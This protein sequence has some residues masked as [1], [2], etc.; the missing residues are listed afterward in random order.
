MEFVLGLLGSMLFWVGLV[1][2][3]LVY[4][5]VKEDEFW[6]PLIGV[7]VGFAVLHFFS[8][9]PVLTYVKANYVQILTYGAYYMG[10]GIIWSFVK[11]YLFLI[12][13]KK[14]YTTLRSDFLRKNKLSSLAN[15]PEEVGAA[16]GRELRYKN[17]PPKASD[18]KSRI[19]TWMVYWAF[20]MLGT[21]L[22]DFLT[23]FFDTIYR[24]FG[25]LYDRMTN[26]VWKD[27][28]DEFI[29]EVEEE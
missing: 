10:I 19:T 4:Y 24:M 11:W 18:N 21:F 20:S 13:K 29:P 7:I 2:S 8:S 26:L 12:K 16:W 23:Q 22:G 17:F 3:Y 27:M 14:E 1:L 28:G 5:A 6:P 25:N 15:M 9:V